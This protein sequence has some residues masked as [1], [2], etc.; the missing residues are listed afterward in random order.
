MD[1]KGEELQTFFI[2]EVILGILVA[3]ILLS[4]ATNYDSISNANA[5]YLKEDVKLLSETLLSSPG[6]I[7]YNYSLRKTFS[8]SMGDSIQVTN[9]AMFWSSKDKYNL[10]FNKLPN[11]NQLEVKS[12]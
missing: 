11:S 7:T 1:K 6:E 8:V 9:N 3:G 2:I 10:I 4:A 12:G 5:N